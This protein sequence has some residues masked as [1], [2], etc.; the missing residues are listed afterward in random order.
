VLT[1]QLKE[2]ESTFLL[3][4]KE[5]IVFLLHSNFP[6]KM[7]SIHNIPAICYDLEVVFDSKKFS[8][9]L[10]KIDKRFWNSTVHPAM[11]LLDIFLSQSIS[12]PVFKPLSFSVIL[13]LYEIS[14][15]PPSHNL[16]LH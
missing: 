12:S 6:L 3:R 11:F 5:G 10:K 9:A 15:N 8:D 16:H 2:M 7:Y 4:I 13:P 1:V 14:R